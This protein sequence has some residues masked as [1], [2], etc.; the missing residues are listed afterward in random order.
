MKSLAVEEPANLFPAR[1]DAV[2]YLIGLGGFWGGIGAGM[3]ATDIGAP[4]FVT[5]VFFACAL[6]S[7]PLLLNATRRLEYRM[8]GQSVRPWPF[9]YVSFRTQVIATLPPTVMAAAQRLKWNAV[10]VTVA[11]YTTLVVRLIALVALPATR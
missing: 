6:G 4:S 7:V 11:I 8:T 9:G 3:V 2:L 1:R 10:V 5:V